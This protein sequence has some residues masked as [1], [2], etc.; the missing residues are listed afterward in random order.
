MEYER[1]CKLRGDTKVLL[2]ATRLIVTPFFEVGKYRGSKIAK[3][4]LKKNIVEGSQFWI[5]QLTNQD[6]PKNR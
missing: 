5:L 3:I 4:A 6:W 2:Q 1:K